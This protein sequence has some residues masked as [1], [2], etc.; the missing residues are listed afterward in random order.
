MK[1]TLGLLFALLVVAGTPRVGAATYTDLDLYYTDD[2]THGGTQ[3]NETESLVGFFQLKQGEYDGDGGNG[4]GY[5]PVSEE[6]IS[7]RAFFYLAN[8]DTLLTSTVDIFLGEAQL[9]AHDG[10]EVL[11]VRLLV[12]GVTGTALFDLQEDG[13]LRY[14]ITA[15]SG[16]L[17]LLEAQ[18][19]AEAGPRSI[20]VPDGGSSMVLL[21][22]VFIAL[23]VL[24]RRLA[25]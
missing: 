23:G 22:F 3:I 9:Q 2:T 7:A 10:Q 4:T 17:A 14:E 8:G 5:N 15:E 11:S 16:V 6:I 1:T 20:G 18:I 25:A 24:K 19:I 13:T 12:G 21:G